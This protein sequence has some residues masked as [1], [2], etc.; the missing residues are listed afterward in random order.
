MFWL[1]ALGDALLL[2]AFERA[3]GYRTAVLTDQ[4]EEVP[5]CGFIGGHQDRHLVLSS[6]PHA[7]YWKGL[8]DS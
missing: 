8:T 5:L 7:E 4:V 1:A 3:V 6:R 2:R